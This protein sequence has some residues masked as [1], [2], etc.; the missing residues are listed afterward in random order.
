MKAVL[1]AVLLGISIYALFLIC[2][3]GLDAFGTWL[4]GWE[5]NGGVFASA[6]FI[7]LIPSGL[8]AG[9][10]FEELR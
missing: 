1:F 5:P 8:A 7:G 6:L 3:I 9:Y 4:Y 2:A 10:I